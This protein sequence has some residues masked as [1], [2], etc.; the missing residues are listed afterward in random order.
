MRRSEVGENLHYILIASPSQAVERVFLRVLQGGHDVPE[1]D[2]RRRFA[3]SRRHLIEDYL[4]LADEWVLWDNTVPPYQ[5]V[6][7][8]KTHRVDDIPAMLEPSKTQEAPPEEMSE[9]VRLGLEAGRIATAKMLEH[10][11]RMGVEVTPQMTLARPARK[12]DLAAEG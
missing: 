1:A 9:M 2:I 4:P 12:E 7:D 6:A 11:M 5:R 10:Y 8:S 3:R